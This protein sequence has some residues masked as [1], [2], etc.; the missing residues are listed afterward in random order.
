MSRTARILSAADGWS[1][2]LPAASLSPGMTGLAQY[3]SANGP[4]GLADLEAGETLV[5]LHARHDWHD[6]AE[7]QVKAYR[8]PPDGLMRLMVGLAIVPGPP[9]GGHAVVLVG[10]RSALWCYL[11]PLALVRAA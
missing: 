3:A 5:V 6:P 2:R 9:S 10:P 7:R 4:R 1:L 11:S 8:C